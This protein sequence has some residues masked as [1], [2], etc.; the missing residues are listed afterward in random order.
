VW[1]MSPGVVWDGR[2]FHGKYSN[3]LEF[4]GRNQKRV[5]SRPQ[6]GPAKAGGRTRSMRRNKTRKGN[7]KTKGFFLGTRR[8]K[9]G[10]DVI[11]SIPQR[12]GEIS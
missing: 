10:S 7:S 12:E 2:V 3:L 1:E 6:E 11:V 5:N 9:L 4:G 8:R